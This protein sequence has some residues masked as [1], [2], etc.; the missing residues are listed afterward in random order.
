LDFFFGGF[1]FSRFGVFL[2]A[3]LRMIAQ[4]ECQ[5]R[6]VAGVKLFHYQQF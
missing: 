5:K 2:L 3:M 1:F 6:E 4:L